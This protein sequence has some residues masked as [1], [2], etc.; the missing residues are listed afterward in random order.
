MCICE[1][2]HT[3]FCN[4]PQV[5]QPRACKNCQ[6]LRQ[7]ANELEWRER[8]PDLYDKK[9][10]AIK[11]QLRDDALT[12]RAELAIEYLRAGALI[13]GDRINIEK[14]GLKISELFFRVGIFEINKLWPPNSGLNPRTC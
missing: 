2:C 5:K 10:H 1:F 6:R 12:K 4:R 11:K 9:Y 13:K 3:P 7:Q 14:F 8:H